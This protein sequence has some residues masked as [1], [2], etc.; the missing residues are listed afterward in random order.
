M[1]QEK[2]SQTLNQDIAKIS[3]R[4]EVIKRTT[5]ESKG[6][7]LKGGRSW[8]GGNYLGII[9]DQVAHA[10]F[11][12]IFQ[13]TILGQMKFCT[14]LIV[15]PELCYVQIEQRNRHLHFVLSVYILSISIFHI[16]IYIIGFIFQI[17]CMH[18]IEKL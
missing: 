8:L 14:C 11:F 1:A 17:F 18:T 15:G 9:H 7:F 6:G 5:Q 2:V 13:S 12:S 3:T 4:K 10:L 16:T